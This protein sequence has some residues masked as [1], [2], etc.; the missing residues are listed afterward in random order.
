MD[1]LEAV[2]SDFLTL[3]DLTV[4]QL[5]ALFDLADALRGRRVDL[6]EDREVA[7]LFEKPSTRTRVSFSVAV[8]QLGGASMFLSS[9]DVQLKRGETIRDTARTLSRYVCGIVCRTFEH[10]R[11]A[12]L[13]EAASVP[14]VNALTDAAHP[15]QALADLYTVRSHGPLREARMAY[16]GDGNN[17]CRSLMEAAALVGMPLRVSTPPA[18]RPSGEHME[19]LARQGAELEWVEDPTEAVRASDFV[20]TDVWAS[21]GDEEDAERRRRAFE[22]YQ[23]NETLL[24]HAP[25][26]VRVM[27]CLPAHR[28][29]EI[30][31]RVMDGP[32]AIVFDQA[33]NRLHVQKALLAVLLG[34]DEKRVTLLG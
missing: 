9:D 3:R 16:V 11:L 34:S 26:G 23:V 6:L 31:D 7:M 29:E 21:M 15:C 10:E 20:Y 4:D 2:P 27:H 1:P 22:D 28:G 24:E 5:E 17:V 14:V 19:K 12:A 18:Y 33:E 32:R 13:A 30:T 8:H 25:D